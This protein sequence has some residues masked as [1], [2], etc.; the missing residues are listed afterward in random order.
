MPLCVACKSCVFDGPAHQG[1]C[2]YFG[3]GFD[4]FDD[5][6]FWN[7][8]LW[9]FFGTFASAFDHFSFISHAFPFSCDTLVYTLG[10]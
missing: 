7:L 1:N 6:D 5:L 8:D 2:P 10:L 3:L 9:N 4:H